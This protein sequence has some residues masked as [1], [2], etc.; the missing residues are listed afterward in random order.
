MS[1]LHI[2]RKVKSTFN[3]AAP[4]HRDAQ[5]ATAVNNRRTTSTTRTTSEKKS[6]AEISSRL[7]RQ[8]RPT[9]TPAY[10]GSDSPHQTQANHH[11]LT[12][13]RRRLARKASTFSLRARRWK[14]EVQGR[15]QAQ[16]QEARE[17]YDS[18]HGKDSVFGGSNPGF[19]EE[20]KL[21]LVSDRN[22]HANVQEVETQVDN[23]AE[24]SSTASSAVTTIY[25]AAVPAEPIPDQPG[26]LDVALSKKKPISASLDPVQAYI[27]SEQQTHTRK[28]AAGGIICVNDMASEQAAPPV[29]YTHLKEITENAC[30][31]A[32][33]NVT[34]YSHAD[35]ESWN[36]TIINSILGALVEETAKSTTGSTPA[37]P[38]FKYVVNSTIIQHA[39]GSSSSEGKTG[40]RRGMHAASGAYWN[41]EKDGMWSYKY[42][43]AESKG[44]D[45]VVGIIWIWVG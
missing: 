13:F 39:S 31:A 30:S 11:P 2:L 27:L 9:P 41:N 43:G 37:Q 1:T 25:P 40:G 10:D 21:N 33:E 23:Q 8:I 38:Q 12:D 32:L 5:P 34:A 4:P 29:P 22:H 6:F 18:T 42:P 35:T 7:R 24:N 44:L 3:A 16:E 19:F 36:T 28:E 45:V 15:E 17:A 20:Q 26:L 14:A